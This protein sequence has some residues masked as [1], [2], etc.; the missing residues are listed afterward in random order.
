MQPDC[1]VRW[2]CSVKN[3][4]TQYFIL[5]QREHLIRSP[6]LDKSAMLLTDVFF[7]SIK[8]LGSVPDINLHRSSGWKTHSLIRVHRRH[9]LKALKI[10]RRLQRCYFTSLPCR[11][12][13]VGREA[14]LLQWAVDHADLSLPTTGVDQ[15]RL[16]DALLVE[17]VPNKEKEERLLGKEAS[18][19]IRADSKQDGVNAATEAQP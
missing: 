19:S 11:S 5:G 6:V 16:F 10:E 15:R 2:S 8:P 7:V 4:G 17:D 13:F 1:C 14:E 12:L 9:F 18:R 3:C